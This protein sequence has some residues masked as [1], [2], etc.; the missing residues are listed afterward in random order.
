MGAIKVGDQSGCPFVPSS[1]KVGA[2][3]VGDQNGCPFVPSFRP[4]RVSFRPFR[5][6]CPF[7]PYQCEHAGARGAAEGTGSQSPLERVINARRDAEVVQPGPRVS[8]PFRTGHQCEG[9]ATAGGRRPNV[10]IPFRTG[11]QCEITV[12]LYYLYHFS[13]GLC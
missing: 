12:T 4:F 7:V 10:S 11:H 6:W 8:I 1:I 5:P 13:I 2:I 3:K 9:G